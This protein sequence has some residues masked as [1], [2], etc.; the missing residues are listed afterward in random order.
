MLGPVVTTILFML[1]FSLALGGAGRVQAGMPF[2]DFLAPGLVMM[3]L[4]QNAFQNP[5]SSILISKVQGNIV[6]VL[7]PPLSEGEL[8]VGY[9]FGGVTR[10]VAVGLA[11]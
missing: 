2:V 10:G 1:I 8:A 9:V 3:S 6:D 11:I 5:S 4:I 7:M